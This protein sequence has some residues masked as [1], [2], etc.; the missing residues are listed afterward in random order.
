MSQLT[1][2]FFLDAL[3]SLES[4]MPVTDRGYKFFREISD[5]WISNLKPITLRLTHKQTNRLT[6]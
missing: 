5:Q 1:F 2:M 4:V 3:A 6:D